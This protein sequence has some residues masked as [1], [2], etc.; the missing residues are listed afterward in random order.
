[1]TCH[2]CGAALTAS[3]RFCHK[4]GAAAD[5]EPVASWTA[6]V[7]WAIAGAA[8]G[9]LIAVFVLR[10]QG[11]ASRE[12][13]GAEGASGSVLPA[14]DI[15]QMSPEERASR[16]FDR[17]MRLVQENRADSVRF[18]AP[19]A[20]QAYAQLP[21]LDLDARFHI[22]LLS[23]ARGDGAG[24]L[25]QADTIRRSVRTHLFPLILRAHALE[26]R[27]DSAGARRAY[28]EFLRLETAERARAR[29][30]Y[31]DHATTLD[32]FRAEARRSAP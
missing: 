14:P 7:P 27:G 23:L 9:A 24:A 16:L 25:A 31:A 18:F 30:E 17:V 32:A 5:Q 22:G 12:Q 20:L 8:V 6:G 3:A 29:P 2:S 1:M 28:A 15:S 26:A 21:A 4:C 11:A 10:E 13:G 19:M